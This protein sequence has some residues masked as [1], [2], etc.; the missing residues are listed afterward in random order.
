MENRIYLIFCELG[1]ESKPLAEQNL[2]GAFVTCIVMAPDICLAI[3]EVKKTLQE[4]DYELYEIDKAM[5]FD[6]DEW[7]HDT[8]II[9]LCQSVIDDKE[10]RY[11][12]FESW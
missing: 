2:S 6:K 7:S 5:K 11:S 4:D 3:D 1:K 8:E 9:S 10:I 12:A